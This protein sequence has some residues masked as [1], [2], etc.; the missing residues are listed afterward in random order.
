MPSNHNAEKPWDTDDIDKWKVYLR[1]VNRPSIT[2]SAK[3]EPFKSEDNLAGTFTEES[4]FS[5]LFPK[6]REQYLKGSWKFITG[7]LKKHGKFWLHGT[8]VRDIH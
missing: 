8:H 5:T 4:R 6:Y 3:I 2:N 7:A 1:H